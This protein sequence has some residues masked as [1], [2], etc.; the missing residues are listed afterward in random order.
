M[1]KQEFVEQVILNFVKGNEQLAE[2]GKFNIQNRI[3]NVV[4]GAIKSREE[5]G[6]NDWYE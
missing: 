4:K 1:E 5:N 6:H 2:Q 3:E